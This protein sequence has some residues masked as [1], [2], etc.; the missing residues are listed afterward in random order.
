MTT[1]QVLGTRAE[2]IS[3]ARETPIPKAEMR[4]YR[5][6]DAPHYQVKHYPDTNA[7]ATVFGKDKEKL[8]IDLNILL[9]MLT[10]EYNKQ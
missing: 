8:L 6:P 4:R 3:A 10:Q 7:S 9:S 1:Q 2:Y 5:S